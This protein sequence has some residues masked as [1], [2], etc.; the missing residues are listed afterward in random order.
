MQTADAY[1]LLGVA[2]QLLAQK[3]KLD[4]DNPESGD[5]VYD[6]SINIRSSV[7]A[8]SALEA[9]ALEADSSA[10]NETMLVEADMPFPLSNSTLAR[11]KRRRQR[12]AALADGSDHGMLEEM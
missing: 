7:P 6:D 1:M 9:A 3:Y 4:P 8:G 12:R 10:T 2:V 5:L 11:I